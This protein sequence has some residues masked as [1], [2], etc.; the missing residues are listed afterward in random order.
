MVRGVSLA[1]RIVSGLALSVAVV[2]TLVV[3]FTTAELFFG[4]SKIKPLF[5]MSE[6]ALARSAADGGHPYEPKRP[7]R[8][9]GP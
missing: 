6:E 5:G 8:D 3:T 7:A 1:G 4:S 9:G 2:F